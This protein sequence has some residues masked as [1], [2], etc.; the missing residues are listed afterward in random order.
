MSHAGKRWRQYA[1]MAFAYVPFERTLATEWRLPAT[2]DPVD[3]RTVD[4]IVLSAGYP[5]NGGEADVSLRIGDGVAVLT[6]PQRNALIVALIDANR[7]TVYNDA[8]HN[9]HYQEG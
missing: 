5:K 3:L 8:G 2:P 4:H 9:Q 7:D 6:G 1:R